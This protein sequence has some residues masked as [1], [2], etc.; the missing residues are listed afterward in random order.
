MMIDDNYHNYDR[1]MMIDDD[2]DKYLSFKDMQIDEFIMRSDNRKKDNPTTTTYK[3]LH[4]I[5]VQQ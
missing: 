3:N 4:E 5:I 1:M 2:D